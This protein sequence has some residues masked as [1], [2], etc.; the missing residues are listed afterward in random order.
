M[1]EWVE[2]REWGLSYRM[3]G[4]GSQQI[5]TRGTWQPTLGFLP[6]ESLGFWWATVHRVAESHTWLKRLSSISSSRLCNYA[7]T[8]SRGRALSWDPRRGNFLDS[9]CPAWVEFGA[10]GTQWAVKAAK[11]RLGRRR[12]LRCGDKLKQ[13]LERRSV[14]QLLSGVKDIIGRGSLTASSMLTNVS[15]ENA[16]SSV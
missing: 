7:L 15:S 6:G 1:G 4:A 8:V 2:K 10:T 14:H 16:M 3:R 12:S 9:C 13:S 11:R 5:N